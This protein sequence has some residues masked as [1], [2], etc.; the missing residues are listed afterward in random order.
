MKNVKLYGTFRLESSSSSSLL[1]V[2]Y[3]NGKLNDEQSYRRVSFRE[4]RYD[5]KSGEIRRVPLQAEDYDNCF[6]R[7]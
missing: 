7:N 1:P 5:K 2:Q 3:V 6:M 4:S